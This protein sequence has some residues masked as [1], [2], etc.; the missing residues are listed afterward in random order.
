MRGQYLR[1]AVQRDVGNFSGRVTSAISTC[2]ASFG[3]AA[4]AVGEPPWILVTLAGVGVFPPKP[5]LPRLLL[6]SSRPP[7]TSKE[8]PISRTPVRRGSVSVT[9][10]LCKS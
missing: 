7:A 4:R 2:I 8:K 3:G 10:G 1:F 6:Q 5:T 9:T